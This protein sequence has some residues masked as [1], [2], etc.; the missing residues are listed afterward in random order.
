MACNKRIRD[1]SPKTQ[2]REKR[3]TEVIA[4]EECKHKLKFPPWHIPY[5]EKHRIYELFHELARELVIQQPADH[6]LFLKQILLQAVNSRDVTRIVIL[7]SPKVNCIEI[8]EQMGAKTRKLVIADEDINAFY[9]PRPRKDLN[10]KQFARVLGYLIRNKKASSSGWILAE[11][12]KT[13]DEAKAMLKAGILPTHVLHLIPPFLPPLCE[14]MYCNVHA[15]WPEYRRNIMGIRDVF[16]HC[17]VEVFLKDQ[18]IVEVIT[19][20]AELTNIRKAIVPLRPTRIVILGPK[21]CGRKTQAK[22]FNSRMGLIH[23]DFEQLLNQAWISD[24]ELGKQ[25]RA[26]KDEVCFQSD[27]LSQIINKR[28]LEDDCLE[29]GWVLT[30]FPNNE[31][32]FRHL[33][34]LDTPPNRVVFLECDLNVC[35]ERLKNKRINVFTG[36]ETDIKLNPELTIG[37]KL[38]VHPKDRIEVINAE[39]TYYCENYGYMRNYCGETATV[40]NANQ[41]ER[42][43]FE[44]IAALITQASP[45]C[46]PR[47]PCK[48]S[49]GSDNLLTSSGTT[50][51]IVS[52]KP[53]KPEFLYKCK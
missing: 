42:W 1:F 29:K 41:S 20:C 43:V 7:A 36:S 8:A 14:L 22:M 27:L 23:V 12:V 37:K 52:Q 5:M 46:P 47:N 31:I 49:E 25:L 9:K 30:G 53:E 39:I 15:Y 45:N 35:R 13:I 44:C 28:I 40:I 32:D 26:C 18:D 48:G 24:S 3:A 34:T 2:C 10:P 16:K 4:E 21:G 19:R 6:V 11:C 51:S 50:E 33:D 38:A 17:L